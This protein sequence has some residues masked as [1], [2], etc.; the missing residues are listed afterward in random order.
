MKNAL[1][2]LVTLE[3]AVV[4]TLSMMIAVLCDGW[5]ILVW[6]GVCDAC[7]L[8]LMLFWHMNAALF[9]R[10]VR[11]ALRRAK[12]VIGRVAAR[13]TKRGKSLTIVTFPVERV[14]R[15]TTEVKRV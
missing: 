2:W 4:L 14:T 9:E 6:L 15:H 11:S 1:L 3:A 12:K 7:L 5:R 13:P 8:W 10:R